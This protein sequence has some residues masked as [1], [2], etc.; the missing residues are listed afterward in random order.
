MKTKSFCRGF[1]NFDEEA[2]V[3]VISNTFTNNDKSTLNA[4]WLSA[5]MQ[6]F[7]AEVTFSASS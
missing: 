3:N 1:Q 7:V 2:A 6:P 5:L 4:I